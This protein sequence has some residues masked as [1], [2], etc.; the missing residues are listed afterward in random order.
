[1]SCRKKRSLACHP[2]RQRSICVDQSR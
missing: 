2:E 1:M